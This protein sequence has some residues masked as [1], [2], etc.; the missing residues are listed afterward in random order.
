MSPGAK[1][2]SREVWHQGRVRTGDATQSRRLLALAEVGAASVC[3]SFAGCCASTPAERA[4]A[5]S[6]GKAE[7]G[8]GLSLV[9]TEIVHDDDVARCQGRHQELLD[10]SREGAAVDRPIEHQ[11]RV[12]LR[13]AVQNSSTVAAG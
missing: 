13:T 1:V 12:D 11:G 7:R 2:G 5:L 8:Y 9:G 6:A 3:R 10:V 4:G